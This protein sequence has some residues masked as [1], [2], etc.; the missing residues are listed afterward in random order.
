[1]IGYVVAYVAAAMVAN[2]AATAGGPWS[3]PVIAFLMIGLSITV[4]DRLHDAWEGRGLAIRMGALIGAGGALSWAINPGSGAVVV[5][6]GLAFLASETVDAVA[7]HRLRDRPWLVR[8]NG[9]NVVSAGVDSVVFVSVAF[10]PAPVVVFV[11]WV[12]KVAGG[13]L[14]SLVLN[15][16]R[17]PCRA[18]R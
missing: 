8:S 13:A 17:E 14:W 11:S 3:V 2:L 10:G 5:A 9:S 18:E 16:W 15:R 4:R 7:Y 6:S 1:M 12:A